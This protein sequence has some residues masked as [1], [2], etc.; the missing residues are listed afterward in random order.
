MSSAESSNCVAWNRITSPERG[1]SATETKLGSFRLGVGR[2]LGQH[3]DP[4]DVRLERAVIGACKGDRGA[5]EPAASFEVVGRTRLDVGDDS[6]D[7]L[8]RI[9]PPA[10]LE[11]RVGE[12][13]AGPPD[14]TDVAVPLHSLVVPVRLSAWDR[15][16]SKENRQEREV[17]DRAG[18]GKRR[19]CGLCQLDRQFEVGVSSRI[20]HVPP[21]R[22]DG[23]EHIGSDWRRGR[24]RR[25]FAPLACPS[26]SPRCQLPASI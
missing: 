1:G 16:R 21:S 6:V 10:R 12:L 14:L 23:R 25:P 17:V 19:V 3:E 15:W 8:E 2:L 7:V 20:A 26:R 9:V 22:A 4:L 11:G 13:A 18:E 24:A 5:H